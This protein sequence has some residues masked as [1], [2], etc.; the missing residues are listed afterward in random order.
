[1]RN[2]TIGIMATVA[3]LSLAALPASADFIDTFETRSLGSL[4]SQGDTVAAPSGYWYIEQKS[5]GHTTDVIDVGGTHGKVLNVD[6]LDA[7]W[8]ASVRLQAHSDAAIVSDATVSYDINNIPQGGA[9][10]PNVSLSVLGSDD[11]IASEVIWYDD[12]TN[13]FRVGKRN[14]GGGVSWLASVSTNTWYNVAM[15]L[16]L[17]TQTWDLTV[18]PEGGSAI[19]NVTG[20][21]ASWGGNPTDYKY[22]RTLGYE[23][24]PYAVTG[25]YLD[26]V[27][28]VP[29]PVTLAL[30]SIGGILALLGRRR[31]AA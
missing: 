16:H 26:N 3:M 25:Y 13:G 19:V 23:G 1:M 2:V 14:T 18:T 28:I 17:G 22:V 30:L 20:L 10:S 8:K 5:T 27:S 29:E 11:A 21:A 7:G 15:V 9:R 4:G 6:D 31:R 24:D 12:G